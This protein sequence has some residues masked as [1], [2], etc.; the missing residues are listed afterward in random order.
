MVPKREGKLV[1]RLP[2][3][4]EKHEIRVAKDS[5]RFFLLQPARTL[6]QRDPV[7]K[8]QLALLQRVEPLQKELLKVEA[9]QPL[10]LFSE[11]PPL[12][13]RQEKVHQLYRFPEVAE[14]ALLV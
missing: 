6:W 14:V 7:E 5:A 9:Y 1:G 10:Q 11:Q 2:E 13:G 8:L 4:L 12:L 3:K